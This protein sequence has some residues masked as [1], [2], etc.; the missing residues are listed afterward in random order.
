MRETEVT[1]LGTAFLN[2]IIDLWKKL[3]LKKFSGKSL[4]RKSIN[5]NGYS[6]SII[7]LSV[8]CIESFITRI[9][10][11]DNDNLDG[12]KRPLEY[13][14]NSI[15]SGNLYRK[16]LELFILRDLI[17]HN[18]LWEINYDFDENFNEKNIKKTNFKGWGNNTFKKN[19]DLRTEKTKFLSL[20]IIPT[21]IGKEDA[22]KVLVVLKEFLDKIS[23]Q[24]RR[25]CGPQL[26][27]ELN[28]ILNN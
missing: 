7:S 21:K 22:K 18:H 8:F 10:Y 6:C 16:L 23:S 26:Y 2:P 5:E 3:N 20:E 24:D 27:R 14:K 28:D 12:M 4:V 13:F 11:I 19:T 25:Y 1:I 17:A 15:D 9:R